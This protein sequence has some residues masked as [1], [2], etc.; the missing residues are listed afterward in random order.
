MVCNWSH[1]APP[2]TG[3]WMWKSSQELQTLWNGCADSNKIINV[4][5]TFIVLLNVLPQTFKN[6][7]VCRKEVIWLVSGLAVDTSSLEDVSRVQTFAS[8]YF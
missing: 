4:F 3:V 5:M 1:S 2:A 6:M 7:V 8:L